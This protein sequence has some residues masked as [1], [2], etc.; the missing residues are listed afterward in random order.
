[1]LKTVA[2]ILQKQTS[3]FV[4]AA[5]FEYAEKPNLVLMYSPDLV[6]K[7]KNAGKDVREAAKA[8]L[9]G[10]GGQPGLATAGGKNVAGLKDAMAR[11]IE[12]ATA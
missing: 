7:G 5:A 9:G 8:I 2:G 6:E 12:L 4:L 3:D 1:M 11:L 10:G